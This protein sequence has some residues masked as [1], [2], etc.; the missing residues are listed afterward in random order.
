MPRIS[1]SDGLMAL[2]KRTPYSQNLRVC[3]VN[4]GPVDF[5]IEVSTPKTKFLTIKLELF[6]SYC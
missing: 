3:V 2:G 1:V 4:L 6:S 5:L